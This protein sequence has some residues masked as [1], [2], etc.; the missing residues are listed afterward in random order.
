[1]RRG[2]I[3]RGIAQANAARQ[4]GVDHR[5][6]SLTRA[7]ALIQLDRF[8]EAERELVSVLA[9]RP[10]DV[11]TQLLLAQLRHIR[12]DTDFARSF[13]EAAEQPDAPRDVRAAYAGTLQQGGDLA[14]AEHLLRKLLRESGPDPQVLAP[15]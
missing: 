10:G 14:R 8:E 6:L 4:L 2:T 15:S 7:R 12:G 9:P 11:E 3:R 5:E 1:M 13:R